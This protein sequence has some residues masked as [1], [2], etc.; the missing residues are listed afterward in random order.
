VNPIDELMALVANQKTVSTSKLEPI[1][2]RA[3]QLCI[4]LTTKVN[5]QRKAVSTANNKYQ[6]EKKLADMHRVTAKNFEDLKLK[7]HNLKRE[8]DLLLQKYTQLKEGG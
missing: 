1:V 3:K 2:Q 5:A 7:H 4:G 6:H 8:H